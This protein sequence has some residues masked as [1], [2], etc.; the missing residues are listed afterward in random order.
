M[1]KVYCKNCNKSWMSTPCWDYAKHKYLETHKEI[2]PGS[3]LMLNPDNKCFYYKRK[4]WKI[5]V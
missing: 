3:L 5:W 2:H 1:N 4:W